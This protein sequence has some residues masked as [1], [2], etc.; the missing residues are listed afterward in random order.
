[1]HPKL[2]GQCIDPPRPV[3]GNDHSFLG[4]SPLPEEEDWG[5]R[6][7]R[8]RTTLGLSQGVAARQLGVDQGTL[9][10]WERGE[11]EPAGSF[12]ER[13]LRFLDGGET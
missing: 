13:A 3:H 2:G 8:R 1:L 10:K 12:L 4:H 9:A 7:V 11:R 6:L 5:K